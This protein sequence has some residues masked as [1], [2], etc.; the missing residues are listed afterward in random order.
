MVSPYPVYPI[1]IAH[2]TG[3]LLAEGHSVRHIDIL[4]DG[5]TKGLRQLLGRSG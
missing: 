4:A 3:A 5:N 2:L 1:G